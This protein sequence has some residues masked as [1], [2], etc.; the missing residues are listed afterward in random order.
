M[1]RNDY[2]G[3]LQKWFGDQ[4]ECFDA[5]WGSVIFI[6]SKAVN[7]NCSWQTD[8]FWKC[9]NGTLWEQNWLLVQTV[10]TMRDRNYSWLLDTAFYDCEHTHFNYGQGIFIFS[11]YKVKGR[12]IAAHAVETLQNDASSF[13]PEQIF[14]TGFVYSLKSQKLFICKWTEDIWSRCT[15]KLWFRALRLSCSWSVTGLVMIRSKIFWINTLNPFRNEKDRIYIA[16]F[17]TQRFVDFRQV[18]YVFRH[19]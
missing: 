2:W 16:S 11:S 6:V 14:S 15:A 5:F 3:A 12:C 17:P 4:C 19:Y 9:V 1:D 18:G 13:N 8:G 7:Q 10:Q